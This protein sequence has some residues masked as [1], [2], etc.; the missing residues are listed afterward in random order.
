MRAF[1][2]III[3]EIF[4]NSTIPFFYILVLLHTKFFLILE[5]CFHTLWSCNPWVVPHTLL[6]GGHSKKLIS[7][8]FEKS[9]NYFE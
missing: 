8:P 5:L 4:I 7:F 6:K 1:N 3:L 9:S 2:K